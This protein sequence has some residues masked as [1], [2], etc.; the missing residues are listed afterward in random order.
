MVDA[1]RR[2]QRVSQVGIQRRSSPVCRE[3]ADLVRSGGIGHVTLAAATTSAMSTPT[4]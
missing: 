4:E 1:V 2:N 3:A